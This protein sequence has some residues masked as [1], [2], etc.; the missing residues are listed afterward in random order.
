MRTPRFDR[1][2]QEKHRQTQT[3]QEDLPYL[4][5]HLLQLPDGGDRVEMEFLLDLPHQVEVL[6]KGDRMTVDGLEEP[7]AT[8]GV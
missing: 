3:E 1:H 4:E 8:Q 7:A 5:E 2:E 6:Q